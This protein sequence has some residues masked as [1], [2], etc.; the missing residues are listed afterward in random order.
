MKRSPTLKLIIMIKINFQNYS[1]Y[2]KYTHQYQTI[3]TIEVRRDERTE[4]TGKME[5]KKW[6]MLHV[7]VIAFFS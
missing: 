3:W 6:A 7:I 1:F 4:I 5:L 2:G